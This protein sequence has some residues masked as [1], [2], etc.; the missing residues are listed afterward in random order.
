MQWSFIVDLLDKDVVRYLTYTSGS[1]CETKTK[2]STIEVNI[3]LKNNLIEYSTSL[4]Y[5]EHI[6]IGIR[7][8]L[9]MGLANF[10]RGLIS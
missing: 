7:V 3:Q 9:K 4:E 8:P 10:W 5:S 2:S 6:F 1:T